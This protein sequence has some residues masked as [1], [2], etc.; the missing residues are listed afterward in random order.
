MAGVLFK[1]ESPFVSHTACSHAT[2][3]LSLMNRHRREKEKLCDVILRVS[4]R[5]IATHRAVL[6]ACSPYFFAMFSGEL[7]ESRAKVVVM[8]DIPSDIMDNLVEFA[9]TGRIN[10]TV[11]NVQALLATSSLIQFH[12]VGELCCKFLETQLD[13]SNCLGIRKFVEAHGCTSFLESVDG[14]VLQKF[15]DVV[16][17][18][19][20]YLLPG[21][22]LIK[23]LSSDDLNVNFEEEVYES[24]LKWVGYNASERSKL[25]PQILENVRLPLISKEYLLSKIDNEPLI[26]M[27]MCCRDLLDEAKNF[28]LVP[29]RRAL[30]RSKRT[31]PR[32]STVGWLFA[33][34]G[35]EAGETIAN[36]VECFQ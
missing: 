27:S 18:D 25:L 21:E 16:K 22:L 23:V 20:Y 2:R 1:T 9:Y 15:K 14:F 26:R 33:V 7:V 35:K 11:E 6:A 31:K 17:S 13:P 30:M 8:Q 34:G 5:D 36:S 19:E 32:K 10:I 4:G 24:V 29:D 3:V 12:E 28:H